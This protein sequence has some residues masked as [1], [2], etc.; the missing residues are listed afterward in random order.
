MQ[1]GEQT[2]PMKTQCLCTHLTSFGGSFAVPPNTID[3]NTVFTT[4][5]FLESI[6]V[7]TTV[8]ALIAVY[9]LILVWA[10]RMDK[11]DIARVRFLILI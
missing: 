5:K 1:V 10:R 6:P 9:L 11:A 7:F 8:I 4:E 3:F 2:T